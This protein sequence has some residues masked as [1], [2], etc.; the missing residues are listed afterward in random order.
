MTLMTPPFLALALTT[1]L[2]LVAAPAAAQTYELPQ[3]PPGAVELPPYG[4]PS[5][6][7]ADPYSGTSDEMPGAGSTP[8]ATDGWAMPAPG[9]IIARVDPATLDLS[10][11]RGPGQRSIE[12]IQ[13]TLLNT[14]GGFG[15][16]GAGQVRK[17]G[18]TYLAEVETPRGEWFTVELDPHA[19][20]IRR[21]GP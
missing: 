10:D 16:S 8:P 13:T 7:P 11:R 1:S 4:A 5:P 12:L 18:E 20:T 21:V 2:A 19:G 14:L 6:L 9:E 17:Q 15:F 3:S